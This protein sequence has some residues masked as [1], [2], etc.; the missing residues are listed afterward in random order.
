[1]NAAEASDEQPESKRQSSP[2]SKL[3]TLEISGFVIASILLVGAVAFPL[4]NYVV[5]APKVP[6]PTELAKAGFFIAFDKASA[7]ESIR[8]DIET[9]QPPENRN[10]L[11]T[12]V[13][14]TLTYPG[15]GGAGAFE[16]CFYE[17]DV[18]GRH[19]PSADD[20]WPLVYLQVGRFKA[21]RSELDSVAVRMGG[22]TL[23][24]VPD[25]TPPAGA[26]EP[27]EWRVY[28]LE[29]LADKNGGDWVSAILEI[30]VDP[31]AKEYKLEVSFE[32][33]RTV[34][35]RLPSF[36]YYCPRNYGGQESVETVSVS[37][38]W[39]DGVVLDKR[40]MRFFEYL[41]GPNGLVSERWL[42]SPPKALALEPAVN[43]M[44]MQYS[45]APN[46]GVILMYWPDRSRDVSSE[47]IERE[48]L[49]DLKDAGRIGK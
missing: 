27:G 5:A 16:R 15:G 20:E 4:R 28:K 1:M 40:H 26:V 9:T 36:W 18:H 6:P 46:E 19:A 32:T 35:E 21:N 2:W 44:T 42:D 25:E 22:D 38:A 14:E 30:G 39:P 37:I 48:Y 43:T 12:Q 8:D 23:Q 3:P 47:A 17:I 11:I 7:I 33:R 49:V 13:D 10:T 31:E 41:D 29:N 34:A 24:R 45:G